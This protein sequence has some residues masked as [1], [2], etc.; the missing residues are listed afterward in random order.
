MIRVII[1]VTNW[2]DDVHSPDFD[3]GRCLALMDPGVSMIF[4]VPF[5]NQTKI[6][7]FSRLLHLIFDDENPIKNNRI[8]FIVPE[9]GRFFKKNPN[10]S[11]TIATLYSYN[12]LNEIK[13]ICA[14]IDS[15]IYCDLVSENDVRLSSALKIPIYGPLPE[16]FD[17][18]SS[19]SKARKILDNSGLTLA[20]AVVSLA[21]DSNTLLANVVKAM[22]LDT[23]VPYLVFLP[24]TK[25]NMDYPR[26]QA[27][28]AYLDVRKLSFRNDPILETFSKTTTAKQMQE[29]KKSFVKAPAK[30]NPKIIEAEQELIKSIQFCQESFNNEFKLFMESWKVSHGFIQACP[31]SDPR[32]M[33]SVELGFNLDWNGNFTLLASSEMLFDSVFNTC[34]FF[35]PQ[36]IISIQDIENILK[37]VCMEASNLGFLGLVNMTVE[38]LAWKDNQSKTHYYA[39]NLKPFLSTNIIKAQTVVLST[40]CTFVSSENKMMFKRADLRIQ[41]PHLSRAKFIDM[42]RLYNLHLLQ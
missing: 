38:L 26:V 37:K 11:T 8:R 12:A 31:C 22:L 5:I 32:D 27:P 42:V 34:G 15:M 10:M 30:V 36:E 7:Y 18:I 1:Q 28:I 39:T 19:R 2:R 14:G 16:V 4:L 23:N 13:K 35:V 40:G 25:M 17:L 24:S 20:P 3:F 29:S 6:N 33:R 41:V 21:M 9:V